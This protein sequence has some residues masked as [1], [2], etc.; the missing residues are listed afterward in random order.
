[1]NCG[2]LRDEM[3]DY[4]KLPSLFSGGF[5]SAAD[6]LYDQAIELQQAGNLEE[7]VGKLEGLLRDSPDYALAHA[8]LSVF[9]GKLDRH[10]EAVEHARKVC[11]LEPDDPFSYMAMS[12]VCQRAGKTAEA[13]QA[14][15]ESIHKQWEMRQKTPS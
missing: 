9:Y 1:M 10:D 3:D 14:M 11:Q 12:I 4:P 15:T 7:A 5:M 8:A 2:K 6:Q 13:E